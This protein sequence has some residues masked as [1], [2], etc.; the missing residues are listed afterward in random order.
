M[1]VLETSLISAVN[2]AY[3][4]CEERLYPFLL[5]AEEQLRQ[6]SKD[7]ALA[8]DYSVGELRQ[9]ITAKRVELWAKAI[10]DFNKQQ[11]PI[12][13]AKIAQT[14]HAYLQ[15]NNQAQYVPNSLLAPQPTGGPIPVLGTG[16]PTGVI[17]YP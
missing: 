2:S 8:P 1:S 11:A 12:L 10:S 5:E 3:D 7:L 16:A 17:V 6:Y 4:H 13:A 15:A 9:A 14:V